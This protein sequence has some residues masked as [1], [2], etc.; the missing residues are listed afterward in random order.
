MVRLTGKFESQLK[1]AAARNHELRA[2]VAKLAAEVARREEAVRESA[3]LAQV[4]ASKVAKV[5]NRMKDESP[6]QDE[7]D[8]YIEITLPVPGLAMF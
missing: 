2:R 5:E 3:E 8:C 6:Y 7:D 1:E 4:Y